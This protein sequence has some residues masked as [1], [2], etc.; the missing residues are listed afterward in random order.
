MTHNEE[1]TAWAAL[2]AAITLMLDLDTDMHEGARVYNSALDRY[3]D[4]VVGMSSKGVRPPWRGVDVS[5]VRWAMPGDPLYV[6][7]RVSRQVF[8]VVQTVHA[9]IA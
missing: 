7:P 4:T 5:G 1:Y 8:P 2:D 9:K 6:R 3:T